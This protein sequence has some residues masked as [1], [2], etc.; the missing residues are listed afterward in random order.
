MLFLRRWRDFFSGIFY[1]TLRNLVWNFTVETFLNFEN[2]DSMHKIEWSM[3]VITFFWPIWQ[4]TVFSLVPVGTFFL[5]TLLF[6]D[7]II[8]NHKLK[9][10]CIKLN[11]TWLHYNFVL[12]I[13]PYLNYRRWGNLEKEN[14]TQRNLLLILVRS[15]EIRFYLAFSVWFRTKWNSV[16]YQTCR[17]SAIIIKFWSNLKRLRSYFSV[18]VHERFFF[19]LTH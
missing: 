12:L 5:H 9:I 15:T 19:G 11:K 14:P 13:W 10:W 17:K 8:S 4:Q 7:D 3:I 1:E 18:S 6:S 2:E 16:W